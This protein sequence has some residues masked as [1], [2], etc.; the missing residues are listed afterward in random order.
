VARRVIS[1]DPSAA[2]RRA[3]AARDAKRVALIAG[4]DSMAALWAQL[5]A[6]QALACWKSLDG[7][8]R[9]LRSD[10]DSRTLDHLRCDTF[11]ERVTGL[12]ATAPPPVEVQV[13]ISAATLL[14]YDT[15]PAQ[16]QGYGALPAGVASRLAAGPDAFLRRLV[17][18]PVDGS[19]LARGNRRYRIPAAL[20]AGI[21]SRDQRCRMP[22]CVSPV[23]E[24]DHVEDFAHGGRTEGRNL[25]G[26]CT[27]SH[28][29][30]HHPG[31]DVT[32]S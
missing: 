29:A 27:R 26:L 8:A 16:L 20:R 32:G 11:Y 7:E 22:G 13:V 6:E 1:A 15:V 14:G 28:H 31:F 30:K 18:D 10:G 12:S 5:P 23:R 21:V 17:A 25:S 4:D 19:L 3:R 9:S 24:V 2:A